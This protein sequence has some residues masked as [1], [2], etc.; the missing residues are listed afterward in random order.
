M[1]I[2]AILAGL[3]TVITW[4]LDKFLPVMDQNIVNK[5]TQTTNL[6]VPKFVAIGYYYLPMTAILFWVK[7]YISVW[8]V[9]F[10]LRVAMRVIAILTGGIVRTD[11]L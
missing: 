1:I 6:F 5:L 4:A 2:E 10:T 8:L 11:K 7:A 9:V 3:L